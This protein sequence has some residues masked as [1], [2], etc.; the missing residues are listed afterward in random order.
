M[1]MQGIKG[2][3]TDSDGEFIGK[4]TEKS[5]FEIA[6]NL[7]T[8]NSALPHTERKNTIEMIRCVLTDSG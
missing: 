5:L 1:S 4:R 2:R 7:I 8:D 3:R 6:G